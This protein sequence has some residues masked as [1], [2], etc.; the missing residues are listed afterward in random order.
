[1]KSTIIV[2]IILSTLLSTAS[3]ANKKTLN[4][5]KNLNPLAHIINRDLTKSVGR[6]NSMIIQT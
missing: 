4:L 2:S 6:D 1:M 3:F 5:Q